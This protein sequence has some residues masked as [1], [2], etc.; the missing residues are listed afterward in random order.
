MPTALIVEDEPEANK[1]LGM[2]V[3]LRGYRPEAAYRGAEAL[4][5]VRRHAPDVVLL[6]LMLPDLDGYD[7]CR[8]LK[9]AG[10]TS[11]VPVII[12]TARITA[13]NRIESFRAG[14][15]AYIP[16]PYTPEQIFQALE[17]S[18]VWRE[19]IAAPRVE[20]RVV[21]DGRDDGE[22]LRRLAQLR[23][24]LVARSGLSLDEVERLT[25]AIKALWPSAQERCRRLG[26][27]GGTTMSYSVNGLGLTL[28][29]YDEQGSLA[30]P[31]GAL[32]EEMSKNLAAA[33]F[34]QIEFDDAACCLRLFKRFRRS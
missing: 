22:T 18:Q 13:E 17:E 3:Q 6:D 21:L 11:L 9:S 30:R 15:D 25:T 7:V 4:E 29:I 24:L 27:R 5:R 26:S 14:A 32:R 1:L 8:S 28:T 20:G 10:A 12:V 19:Q 23:S 31:S 2:L 33:Q 16:K 34:D